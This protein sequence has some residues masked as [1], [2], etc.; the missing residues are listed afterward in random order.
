MAGKGTVHGLG[1]R[2]EVVQHLLLPRLAACHQLCR[3]ESETVKSL[4]TYLLSSHTIS[5]S[6]SLT[7]SLFPHVSSSPM[8]VRLCRTPGR[9]AGSSLREKWGATPAAAKT[10]RASPQSSGRR[11]GTRCTPASVWVNHR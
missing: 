10:L 11:R 1:G 5:L 2:L 9:L 4:K 8:D 3:L 7:L 6:H